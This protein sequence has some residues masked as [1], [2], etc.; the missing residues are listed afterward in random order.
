MNRIGGHPER[1]IRASR[2][3]MPVITRCYYWNMDDIPRLPDLVDYP[4]LFSRALI[5]VG[6]GMSVPEALESCAKEDYPQAFRDVF[7]AARDILER[8][9]EAKGWG[10]LRSLRELAGNPDLVAEMRS[11]TKAASSKVA[12]G[13]RRSE[14]FADFPRIF[15]LAQRKR[16]SGFSLVDSVEMAVRELY[17]HTY[18]KTR[19]AA[20]EC[21]RLAARKLEMH[22]LR[23]LRELAEDPGL[24][25][26]L[27]GEDPESRPDS[28]G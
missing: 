1:W 9:K 4:D 20:L 19:D 7:T 26:S 25:R 14:V 24:F 13:K 18:R 23:A 28:G 6:K 21:V 16:Q 15:T 17:P 5:R 8:L 2:Q 12:W 22:E 3:A 10:S 27:F 11:E